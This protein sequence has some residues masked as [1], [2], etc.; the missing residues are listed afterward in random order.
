MMGTLHNRLLIAFLIFVA[1]A[2]AGCTTE[3]S[4]VIKNSSDSPIVVTYQF[5]PLPAKDGAVLP[6]YAMHAPETESP[7]GRWDW[8]TRWVGFPAGQATVDRQQGTVRVTLDAAQSLRVAHA[9]EYAGKETWESQ[10]RIARLTITGAGTQ[11]D[12]AG[13][14]VRTGFVEAN[15]VYVLEYK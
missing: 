7:D 10:V 3:R 12:L 14:Q 1:A 5:A 8:E 6:V 13:D 2:A 9:F 15:G 11:L 4:F